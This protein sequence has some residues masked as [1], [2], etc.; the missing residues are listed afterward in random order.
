MKPKFWIP[1]PELLTLWHSASGSIPLMLRPGPGVFL[2]WEA[3][4]KVGD[5]GVGRGQLNRGAYWA[6]CFDL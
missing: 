4:L 1:G 6:F 3:G 2:R 5:K